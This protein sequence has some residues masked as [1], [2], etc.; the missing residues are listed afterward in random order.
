MRSADHEPMASTAT[1]E[2]I[3]KYGSLRVRSMVPPQNI[4]G[5]NQ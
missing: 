4:T 2:A 3:W 1:A 5:T